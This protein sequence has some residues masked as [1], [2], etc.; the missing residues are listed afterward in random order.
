MNNEVLRFPALREAVSLSRAT[1]FRLEREGKFPARRKLSS[2]SVG[3]L[4]ADVEK[5][6]ESRE[7]VVSGNA[8]CKTPRSPGRP[9]KCRTA[10]K[11][12]VDGDARV[13]H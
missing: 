12:G 9:P 8:T 5:W 3:W 13:V 10:K 2:R 6:I 4:R 7:M 11:L 1:I